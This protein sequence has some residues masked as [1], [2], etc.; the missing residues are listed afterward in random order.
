MIVLAKKIVMDKVEPIP[1]YFDSELNSIIMYCSSYTGICSKKT[2]KN[3]C[4]STRS[5][6]LH[7]SID[8][9]KISY[10][11]KVESKN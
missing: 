5:L 2:Q 1:H 11:I 10:K 3:V 7:T 8:L 4:Q 9:Q 6:R